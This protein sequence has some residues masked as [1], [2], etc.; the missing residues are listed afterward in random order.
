MARKLGLTIGG[1]LAGLVVVGVLAVGGGYLWAS[2]TAQAALDKTYTVHEHDFPIPAPL[3]EDEIEALENQLDPVPQDVQ[4]A[5]FVQAD[6][7]DGDE[8]P[9]PPGR[10]VDVLADVDLDEVAR[11]RAVE[12]GEHLATVMY[13]CA[14]CH[15]ADFG[16]GTMID[17]PAIG[18][19]QGP[20]LTLGQGGVTADY[21]PAD[22]DRIVRHGVKP[23]GRSSLM[24]AVDF[25]KMSDRELGDIVSYIRSLPPV[26]REVPAPSYGPLG[27]VL[28]ATGEIQ[29]TQE[30]LDNAEQPHP[31]LPPPVAPDATYG[32]H[33]GQ[34]CAGC[35][36]VDFSGGPI[37]GAP[38]HWAPAA[39][40]TPHERAL[41]R[42][43]FEDFQTL[44]AEGTKPD[45]TPVK[46]PMTFVT[47]VAYTDVELR[48]MWEYLQ[49]VDAVATTPGG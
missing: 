12:R 34:V 46:E 23:D 40:I 47:G 26:D 13:P 43:S 49:T 35:H 27:T 19:V 5:A 41:G 14:E 17:D 7:T 31:P 6:A 32:A 33:I 18:L 30:W 29:V 21:S 20:N 36:G 2:T 15:G 42:Y 9:M 1:G 8:A 24:P 38:P 4:D 25:I 22:W 37:P 3:T 45:G 11:E 39:N 16:G 44:I 48:A 28:I 10:R